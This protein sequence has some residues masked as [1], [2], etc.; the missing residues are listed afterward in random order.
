MNQGS[1]VR[2]CSRRRLSE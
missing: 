2:L 1:G